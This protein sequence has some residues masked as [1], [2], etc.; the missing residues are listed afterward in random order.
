MGAATK[1]RVVFNG[2]SKVTKGDALNSYLM[3]GAN[4]LPPLS[5]VLLRWRRHCYVFAADI[6]KI[7]RQIEIHPLDRDLQ[8]ILWR[9]NDAQKVRE[10][11]LN[12]V[13]YGLASLPGPPDSAIVRERRGAA[14]AHG[15]CHSDETCT[16]MMY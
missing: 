14:L 13:T 8:R 16:W 2:S 10:Y 11:Q 9:E 12:T 15:L 7:Y 1:V 3:T 6:E 4:L 5:D